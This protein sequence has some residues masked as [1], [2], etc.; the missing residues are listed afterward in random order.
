MYYRFSFPINRMFDSIFQVPLTTAILGTE[1]S[2]HGDTSKSKRKSSMS[3]KMI[4]AVNPIDA[5]GKVVSAGGKVVS[6][7]AGMVT[8]GLA[9]AG[10]A[11]N[12]DRKG[13]DFIFTLTDT[14]GANGTA[15]LGELGTITVTHEELLNA[16]KHT[17]TQT[18]PIGDKGAYLEFRIVF[19]GMLV[20]H[21]RWRQV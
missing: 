11:S 2:V 12:T 15:G 21:F 17:L 1:Q 5:A 20:Y 13:L 9:L 10:M 18:R 4:T 3:S 7:G 6:A 8:S 14:V 16:N 19:T